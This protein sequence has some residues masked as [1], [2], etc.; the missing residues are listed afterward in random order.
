MG[1]YLYQGSY[2]EQGLKGILKEGGSKRR[3]T[4]EQLIKSMGGTLEAF[5]FAHGKDDFFIIVDVPD[6]VAAIATALMVNASGA[7]KLRTTVL[8]TP[9]EV[10]QATK[11]TVNY[12]PPGQ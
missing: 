6:P 5:Y 3:E 10:D 9:E 7:V 4:V 11:L 12:R 1:K 8:I 2:T